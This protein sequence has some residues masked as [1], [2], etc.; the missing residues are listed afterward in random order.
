M[1]IVSCW[2]TYT[3]VIA[4]VAFKM[5]RITIMF[6]LMKSKRT[7]NFNYLIYRSV[8]AAFFIIL[9]QQRF[10]LQEKVEASL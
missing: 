9:T 7:K 5:A 3:R 6:R 8:P 10:S 4:H 1:V 2:I